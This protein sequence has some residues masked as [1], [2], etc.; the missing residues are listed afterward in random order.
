MKFLRIFGSPADGGFFNDFAAG[1]VG[2]MVLGSHGWLRP[3]FSTWAGNSWLLMPWRSPSESASNNQV[4]TNVVALMEYDLQ[5]SRC[6]RNYVLEFLDSAW[7][8]CLHFPPPDI[9][10]PFLPTQLRYIDSYRS[11]I[12]CEQISQQIHG[13]IQLASQH[14]FCLSCEPW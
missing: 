9:Y 13:K 1:S 12:F 5:L 3:C 11:G 6:V 4:L 14:R 7:S 10:V 8:S 2:V